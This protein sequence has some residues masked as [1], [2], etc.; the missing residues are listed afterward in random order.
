[1]AAFGVAY[2]RTDIPQPNQLA[3]AQASIIY[4]SDGK[5]EMDRVSVVN[6]ESVP[7]TKIPLHVQRAL[8]AAED[9]TF[10]QNNGVSPTGIAR[11]VVVALKGGPTQGGSTITQQ[12]VKNYFLTQ[13]RTL[14]RKVRE[15]IISI[16]IDQQESKNT[17]LANYLNTIYY[18][19]GASGIQT[20]AKAYFG[21]D[22]SR[23][24]VAQG[25]LLAS[26]IRGPAFYDPALGPTQLANARS[27]VDYVLNGMVTEGW[28]SPA[29]RAKTTF[30][31]VNPRAKTTKPGTVGY[32]TNE[33]RRELK[34][35]LKLTDADI[36]RGGLRIVTTINKYAQAAAVKAVNDNM[37]SEKKAPKWHV[38]LTAIKPGDGA[39]VAMYGG[40][41]YSKVQWNDSTDA[42][43]SP[44]P[45]TL[46]ARSPTSAPA[47]ASSSARSTCGRHWHTRST[48]SSPS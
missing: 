3:N 31:K 27:R 13:D 20:A 28:L 4:Y 30:P 33:V 17:I 29:E 39:I 48:P 35:K 23:L 14:S 26:V 44:A 36:D 25:A 19:R 6:R 11:A 24:T 15:F 47:T 40:K 1:V 43:S 16:K 41:D 10:Y 38:G 12:Y 22:A 9:R 2:A 7:L 42:S 32:I 34:A 45:G 37:P 46:A 18:G 5:T 8:L 21:V